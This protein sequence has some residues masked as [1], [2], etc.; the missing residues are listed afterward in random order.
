MIRV[1]VISQQ[2]AKVTHTIQ[3]CLRSA[4][5]HKQ[6]MH[7]HTRTAQHNLSPNRAGWSGLRKGF[8]FAVGPTQR[9]KTLVN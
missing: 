9:H 2:E 1:R 4:Y 6:Y 3:P 7:M 5:T 8:G